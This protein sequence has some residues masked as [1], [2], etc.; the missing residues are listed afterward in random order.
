MEWRVI[1]SI[2]VISLFASLGDASAADVTGT[3]IVKHCEYKNP[4][5]DQQS[6]LAI[7]LVDKDGNER[8]NI[9]SRLWKNYHGK[10]GVLDKM[11]LYTE[12]P[13]D[14][15]GTGFL[16]WGYSA[17]S[18]M[19][20]DQWLYLPQLGKIRRVSVRDPG[21]SFL[22]SDLTYGD[23]EERTVDADDH[24]L[25]R[26]DDVKGIKLHVVE[27]TPKEKKPLYSK[28]ISWYADVPDWNGC[29]RAKTEFYDPQGNILKV[30]VLT[31]QQKDGAW[32]WDRVV[33][34]NLQTKHK[35][36][37][38]VSDVRVGVGLEDKQFTERDLKKGS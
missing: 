31:W 10:E 32:A 27:S 30:Q 19:L 36:I 7:T 38:E 3:D 37:F 33:V 13:P 26:V 29:Y 6:K 20:A 15:R 25:V 21:D 34:E 18:G 22:G 5:E 9:Y 35:S 28:K 16:R 11:V 17:S 2:V 12:F 23:I 1:R 14:A 8:K 4:G 24:R